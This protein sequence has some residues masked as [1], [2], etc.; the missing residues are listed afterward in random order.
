MK[1]KSARLRRGEGTG[2]LYRQLAERLREEIATGV[3][4]PGSRL[5]SLDQIAADHRVNRLTVRKAIGELRVEGLVYSVPA[6]GTYVVSAA[7]DVA[8]D[9]PLPAERPPVFGLLSHVLHPSGYGLY[10]QTMIAGLYDELARTD[11]NLLVMA[12]GV[13][14]QDEIPAMMRGADASAMIY[15]G[16][17][18]R[19]VLAEMVAQGPPAVLLDAGV[20]GLACDSVC[21]DNAGGARE[22]VLHLIAQ[23]HGDAMAVIAGATGDRTTAER[24]KGAKQAFAEAE[25]DFRRVRVVGGGYRR[26]G[27]EAAMRDLLA[28]G[29]R[30][31]AV[32][33]M[34]DELAAG[35]IEA[36]RR[37]GLRVPADVAVMGFDDSMWAEAADPPLTTMRVDARQ[38]GRLAVR[39]LQARMG[40]PSASP[41]ATTLQPKLVRRASA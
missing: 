10:H 4:A 7:D 15:L 1:G 3:F 11:A 20:C 19:R 36:I 33:C 27:G 5:P 9:D 32:F 30:P 31:K 26:E 37:A 28:S 14:G 24:L 39:L 35:A 21:V 8:A 18:D 38:M 2:Y 16:H 22:A 23:G 34:N 6:Q 40:D 25:L 29:R 12:A 17:F 13:V 41:T